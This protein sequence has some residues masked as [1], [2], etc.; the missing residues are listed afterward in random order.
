MAVTGSCST[1]R[2]AAAARPQDRVIAGLFGGRVALFPMFAECQIK[3]ASLRRISF[4]PGPSEVT[5]L[6]RSPAQCSTMQWTARHAVLHVNVF[7]MALDMTLIIISKLSTSATK[8]PRCCSALMEHNA[9]HG[10][11][12][13]IIT[14]GLQA[15]TRPK[16]QTIELFLW[17][18]LA[19]SV[20]GACRLVIARHRRPM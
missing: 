5:L 10:H 19:V 13:I 20:S 17:L 12:Y 3:M 11:F 2:P 6:T 4:A 1:R 18:R 14:P 7:D 9:I 16:D 15:T 8:L